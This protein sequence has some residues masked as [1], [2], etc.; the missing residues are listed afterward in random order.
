MRSNVD[1]PQPEGPTKTMNSPSAMVSEKL[2]I[3]FFDRPLKR[4]VMFFRVSVAIFIKQM[5]LFNGAK[6]EALH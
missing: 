6:G 3:V 5:E 1:F 4:F 2:S